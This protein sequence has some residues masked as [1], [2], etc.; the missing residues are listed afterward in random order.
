[1]FSNDD[2]VL[3]LV[4]FEIIAVYA[5]TFL[6]NVLEALGTSLRIAKFQFSE[7]LTLLGV[8]LRVHKC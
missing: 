8:R 6:K 5:W 1:M 3:V 7:I 2:E 4:N